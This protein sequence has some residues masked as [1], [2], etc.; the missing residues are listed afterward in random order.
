MVRNQSISALKTS[1]STYPM[2]V[3]NYHW[4]L[5]SS[6]EKDHQ[7]RFLELFLKGK[8]ITYFWI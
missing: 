4:V 5:V 3:I 8:K 6:Y 2:Q 7:I 1:S